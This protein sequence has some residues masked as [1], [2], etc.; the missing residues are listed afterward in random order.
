MTKFGLGRGLADLKAEMGTASE[1][2][3]LAG[4][5]RVVVRNIPIT[6]IVPNLGQ[7]RKT[8]A[9]EELQDLANSI[10]E[11]GV[12]QPILVRASPTDSGKYEIIAGERRWRASQMVGATDIPALVKGVSDENAMEIALIEN[13]QRENLNAIEEALAYRNLMKSC[14]YE[15]A[16]IVKLIGKSES[17]IRN[18]MRL[19]ELP[20]SVQEM[21]KTGKLSSSHARTIAVAE[22]AEE[23]ARQIVTGGLSVA[24]TAKA[25]KES[26]RSKKSRAF[27]NNA[28]MSGDQTREYERRLES[29]LGVPAQLRLKKGGAGEIVLRFNNK[30]Q[31]EQLIQRITNN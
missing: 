24:D 23:L 5:E 17:Y 8:F 30:F 15:M 6:Q 22:N 7:P 27:N 29:V 11:K 18:M 4:G 2:S 20:E 12:L 16:D 26:A 25:V 28:A 9:P 31:M 19:C 1:I 10:A 13:V 14:G 3:V 21:V